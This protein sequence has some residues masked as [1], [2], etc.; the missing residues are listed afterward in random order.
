MAGEG[1]VFAFPLLACV[2]SF[3]DK[4]DRCVCV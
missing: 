2:S 3:C 1:V 4:V